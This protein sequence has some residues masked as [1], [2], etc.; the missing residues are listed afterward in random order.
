MPQTARY[1]IV[2]GGIGGPATALALAG[3]GLPVTLLERSAA[4][5]GGGAGLALYPNGLAVLYGLGLRG[6]LTHAG[7]AAR[8]GEV[9]A[10][11]R[12]HRIPVPDYGH[13]LDHVLTLP[14]AAMHRVLHE[15]AAGA[16]I[17]VRF[18]HEVLGVDPSGRVEVRAPDGGTYD[19]NAGLVIGADGVGS[20]VRAAGAFGAIRSPANGLVARALVPGDPFG[21][22]ATERWA[23]EGL[24][25]GAPMGDGR[26][27]VALSAS[28]GPLR[29]ALAE[30]DLPTLR[31]LAVRMLPE[32]GAALARVGEFGDL[33]ITPVVTVTCERWHDGGTVLLGDAAHAMPPHLGQGANSALLDA[34]VLAEE[35]T[36]GQA[37][38]AAVARYACRR[39]P[40]M[41]RTQRMVRAAMFAAERLTVPVVR[42]SRDAL[43]GAA[44]ALS[45]VRSPVTPLL[46]EDPARTYTA[47]RR[48]AGRRAGR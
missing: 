47:V 33:L 37:Q 3:A 14:R 24:A 41:A 35:L 6:P 5:D 12:A 23:A 9:R 28:G 27:Y 11:R 39:R 22:A 25:L 17:D 44:F 2:G 45:R 21:G 13:G 32:A 1:V 8:H 34:Y 16:G 7:H 4:P 10:G 15:A 43:M 18:G 48:L 38:D 31:A 40:A 46:Q 29:R 19:I 26:S 42:Q 20:A 30:G 36:R